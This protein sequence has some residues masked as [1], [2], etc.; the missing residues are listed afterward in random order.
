MRRI[1][2]SGLAVLAF[3]AMAFAACRYTTSL[4]E[5][6]G[7]GTGFGGSGG[8]GNGGT[9]G[10][11]AG[12][13]SGQDQESQETSTIDGDAAKVDGDAAKTDVEAGPLLDACPDGQTNCGNCTIGRLDCDDI[14]ANGC[15]TDGITDSENCGACGHDCLG[16]ECKAS[17]CQPLE[18][19]K[20]QPMAWGIAVDAQRVYWSNQGS[21]EILSLPLAGGTPTKLATGQN[22]PGDLVID[23]QFVYWTNFSS[24]GAVMRISKTATNLMQIS[25][26]TGPWGL[27][28][29]ATNAWFTNS[30]GTIRQVAKGGGSA[31][32]V[33]SAEQDPK[34]IT[35]DA[36]HLF[37]TA[38]DSGKV[39]K[40]PKTSPNADKQELANGQANP[41]SV[42]VTAD[43]V[44]WVAAG[45]YEFGQCLA[46]DGKV[47]KV[48]KAGGTPVT[49]ATGQACPVDLAVDGDHV[50][51]VNEGTF[52]AQAYQYDGAVMRV[53]IGG[54]A[55]EAVMV[56]QV[57]PYGVAVDDKAVYWTA[58]GLGANAG[59]VVKIVKK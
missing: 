48:A 9:G 38:L 57:V 17:T 26:G 14:A 46:A 39:M 42:V 29:D 4:D 19:A 37:W 6:V 12:G 18:L 33:V 51:F 35:A 54:G 30:D 31:T 43:S 5:F 1:H 59:T 15:E 52:V 16:G 28:V 36:T 2:F 11:A 49:L 44:Y 10:T 58:Q 56:G 22:D 53:P 25:N 23:D 55:A 32:T 40:G 45:N 34:G 41:L 47:M 8:G 3:A 50:Y 20:G 7:G 24:G 27:T 13:D 21:G